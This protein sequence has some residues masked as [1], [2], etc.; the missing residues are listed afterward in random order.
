MSF[1]KIC[2]F[3]L[4]V[5]MLIPSLCSA[6]E[7]LWTEKNISVDETQLN[8]VGEGKFDDV[9]LITRGET[10]ALT[11]KALGMV[12]AGDD[13][14]YKD[15]SPVYGNRISAVTALNIMQGS[16]NG[17]FY[18]DSYITREELAAVAVRAYNAVS[19]TPVS[20]EIKEDA[21]NDFDMISDW[22]AEYV[23][24]AV[25]LKA[26]SAKNKLI[27]PKDYATRAECIEAVAKA[28]GLKMFEYTKTEAKQQDKTEAVQKPQQDSGKLMTEVSEVGDSI[29]NG[30]D[31]GTVAELDASKDV[32]KEYEVYQKAVV[33]N[34]MGT[35]GIYMKARF[36]AGSA[37]K[38]YAAR[39]TEIPEIETS[40]PYAPSSYLRV[41]DPDGTLVGF[42]DFTD[43]EG[44]KA[45]EVVPSVKKEGIW[46]FT[47]TGCR[48]NDTVEFGFGGASSWGIGGMSAFVPTETTPNEMYVYCQPQAMEIQVVTGANATVAFSDET[49]KKISPEEF[50]SSWYKK[51]YT[52]KPAIGDSVYKLEIGKGRDA[53]AIDMAPSLMCP[54]AEMAKDLKGGWVESHGKLMQGPLQA[55]IRDLAVNIVDNCNLDVDIG[56]IPP[57][58]AKEDIKNI[59]AEAQMFGKYAPI[60]GLNYAFDMQILD[61]D[62]IFLGYMATENVKNGTEKFADYQAGEFMGVNL[63][64]LDGISAALR[65]PAQLNYF[66]G[67]EALMR[68]CELYLL[69][70]LYSLSEEM[71]SRE[72]RLDS[73]STGTTHAGFYFKYTT[74]AYQLLKPFLPKEDIEIIEEA[75][76]A[77]A[78]AQQNYR[79][80]VTNQLLHAN[81]GLLCVYISTGIERYHEAWKRQI[82]TVIN[83]V[84]GWDGF[85]FNHEGG[86]YIEQLGCD[87][88]YSWLNQYF[89]ANMYREYSLLDTA[90]EEI[91]TAMRNIIHENMV[92][93]SYAWLT[94]PLNCEQDFPMSD[95]FTSRTKSWHGYINGFPGKERVMDI[96][97][98]AKRRQLLQYHDDTGPSFPSSVFP[99]LL[100]NEDWAYQH[101]KEH[102]TEYDKKLQLITSGWPNDLYGLFENAYYGE[103]KD[104]EPAELPCEGEDGIKEYQ[105][106]IAY[107]NKGIYGY[108]FYNF[109][110]EWTIPG[111]SWMGGGPNIIWSEKTGGSL[112]GQ[113]PTDYANPKNVDSPDKIKHSCVYFTDASGTFIASGKEKASLKWIEENKIWEISGTMPE[114][115]QTVTWRYELTD[116]GIRIAVSLSS[117]KGI[118]AWVNLPLF[119]NNK[120][121]A[122]RVEKYSEGSLDIGRGSNIMTYKWDSD[123]SKLEEAGDLVRNLRIQIPKSGKVTI[124]ISCR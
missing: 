104:M 9:K 31:M 28:A 80:Y 114:T 123:K 49:G 50:N 7:T 103:N 6:E 95:S 18:P 81:E 122:L 99:H 84:K 25:Q 30:R 32:S 94:N 85:G 29:L 90:D 72:N 27:R 68:R 110:Q 13:R 61:A 51:K 93:E 118:T 86:Y 15:V 65:I 37:V 11:A 55:R 8:W 70:G 74:H 69:S 23:F 73:G 98:L 54:T 39:T 117:P 100:N 14:K 34:Q 106:F 24:A 62:D 58:P 38:L 120:G 53:I 59:M 45:I 56:E 33:R 19:Q 76:I 113:K 115:T 83:P 109:R 121:T 41:C 97:P 79:G 35:S 64:A 26:I 42:Y 124:D 88:N 87:G 91:Y 21:Y 3:M 107:K 71:Y 108:T 5:F 22:A 82:R 102:Y 60:S 17:Y 2:A 112:M 44:K 40:A 48:T 101:I 52:A 119:E 111:I 36:S 4:C 105:G 43:I 89:F 12:Y 46:T 96:E 10:A 77:Y 63:S 20:A 67:N 78:D 47:F 57:L 1:K 75:I 116:S 92:F 66:Y 16:S